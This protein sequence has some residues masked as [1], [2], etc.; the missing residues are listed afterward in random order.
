MKQM[1]IAR[2]N[3]QVA[4]LLFRE[5]GIVVGLV[6]LLIPFI[7]RTCAQ[8]KADVWLKAG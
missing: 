5:T 8:E 2:A 7:A 6:D 1:C 4:Y 3:I